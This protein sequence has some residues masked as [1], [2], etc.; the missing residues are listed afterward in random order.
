VSKKQTKPPA[1]ELRPERATGLSAEDR[2]DLRDAER[3][4][5]DAKKNGVYL[6]EWL[7]QE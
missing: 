3:A 4:S 1:R 2:R 5:A 7:K 6:W